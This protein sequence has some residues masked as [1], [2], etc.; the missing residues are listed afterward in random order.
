MRPQR[1]MLTGPVLD[2]DVVHTEVVATT[3]SLERVQNLPQDD[4]TRKQI[5]F[6]T[7]YEDC[8][9]GASKSTNRFE[10]NDLWMA[11]R[12]GWSRCYDDLSLKEIKESSDG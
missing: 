5:A 10:S 9:K 3:P 11:W 6:D 8:L 12:N 7:G 1:M 4:R 2:A